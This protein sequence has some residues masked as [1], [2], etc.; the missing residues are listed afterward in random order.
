M[1]GYSSLSEQR[2]ARQLSAEQLEQR[3]PEYRKLVCPKCG[4]I[5]ENPELR[6]INAVSYN[7][8]GGIPAHMEVLCASCWYAHKVYPHLDKPKRTTPAPR[9]LSNTQRTGWNYAFVVILIV[10][11]ILV[12]AMLAGGN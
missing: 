7:G 12:I 1:S 8:Y 4:V 5:T 2:P 3:L 9:G 11:L 10:F 6:W